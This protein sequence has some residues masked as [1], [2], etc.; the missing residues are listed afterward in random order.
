MSTR[1]PADSP[2]D[3]NTEYFLLRNADN[4]CGIGTYRSDLLMTYLRWEHDP[5]SMIGFGRQI[6]LSPERRKQ[7][8]DLQLDSESTSRFTV[9]DLTSGTPTPA[10]F[11]VLTHANDGLSAEY[12]LLIAP[13]A[14]GR[15]LAREATLLTVDYG[16]H[17]GAL[18][19]IWLRAAAR[20]AP[21]LTVYQKCGFTE[22]GRLRQTRTWLGE[23]CDEVFMDIQ[24]GDLPHPSVI[25]NRHTAH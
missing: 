21:A 9:Y 19:T 1:P 16:L 24:I 8:L 4:T 11:T 3:D 2:A 22:R 7:W 20:N 13:E 18:R 6:P 17:V 23:L 5:A 14:R 10:G 15:G 25:R 12:E